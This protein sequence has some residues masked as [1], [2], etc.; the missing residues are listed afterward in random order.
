MKRF[1]AYRNSM[2]GNHPRDSSQNEGKFKRGARNT[3][4]LRDLSCLLRCSLLLKALLQNWHLYFFSG[5]MDDDFR[6][7]DV[8][9]AAMGKTLTGI[10]A[11]ID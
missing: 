6:I 3:K 8:D 5:T 1:D 10:V 7:V 9:D 4:N 11:V 2:L